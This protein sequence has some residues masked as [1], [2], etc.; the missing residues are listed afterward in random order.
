MVF[1]ACMRTGTPY[2]CC[3]RTGTLFP[4]A[5]AAAAAEAERGGVFERRVLRGGGGH[6]R[7]HGEV[8]ETQIGRR[9]IFEAVE[10]FDMHAPRRHLILPLSVYLHSCSL[11]LPPAVS[12]VLPSFSFNYSL[13]GAIIAIYQFNNDGLPKLQLA[14]ALVGTVSII[15]ESSSML[16]I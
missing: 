12:S 9:H 8:E 7:E 4:A 1:R 6:P 10:T 14:I 13:E 16:S 11:L 3:M 5:A 15:G 2:C